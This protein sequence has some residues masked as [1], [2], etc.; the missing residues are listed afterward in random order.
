MCIVDQ[1]QCIARQPTEPVPL[2]KILRRADMYWESILGVDDAMKE[3]TDDD[4]V[5]F[6]LDPAGPL[7]EII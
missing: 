6:K 2:E 4:R 1:L 5:Q 7:A 3:L